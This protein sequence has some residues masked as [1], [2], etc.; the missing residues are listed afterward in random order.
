[1]VTVQDE[2]TCQTLIENITN[3]AQ[4]AQ[5]DLTYLQQDSLMKTVLEGL[6]PTY[7]FE[8]QPES[9]L[10]EQEASFQVSEN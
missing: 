1:V 3:T 8:L 2:N 4:L 5:A 6:F 7:P 9:Q 10:T